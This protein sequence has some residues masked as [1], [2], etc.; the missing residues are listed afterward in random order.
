MDISRLVKKEVR[1]LRA[2]SAKE[3]P[4]RVKLDAN[5]SPYDFGPAVRAAMSL[6]AISLRRLF[7]RSSLPTC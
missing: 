4:C 6:A 1:T 7:S 5:E 3:I 2:Y